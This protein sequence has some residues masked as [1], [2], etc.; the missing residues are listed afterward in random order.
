MYCVLG[1][2]LLVNL[3]RAVR[4]LGERGYAVMRETNRLTGAKWVVLEDAYDGW[5]TVGDGG[6]WRDAYADTLRGERERRARVF[7]RERE[8]A[9]KR[10]THVWV[11]QK[12][13][14]RLAMGEVMSGGGTSY[15][16]TVGEWIPKKEGE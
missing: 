11:E 8:L 15:V 7:A 14:R 3:E 13:T 5:M 4:L 1:R 16:Q 12:V 9:E 2:G 6:S 10:K